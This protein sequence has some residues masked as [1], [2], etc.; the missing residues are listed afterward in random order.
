MA[1]QGKFGACGPDEPLPDGL[2]GGTRFQRGSE[3]R[4]CLCEVLLQEICRSKKSRD[5]ANPVPRADFVGQGERVFERS[6][7]LGK[8]EQVEIKCPQYPIPKGYPLAMLDL[9]GESQTRLRHLQ[10]PCV[11][12]MWTQVVSQ[13]KECIGFGRALA[14]LTGNLEGLLTKVE[15][16]GETDR[17]RDHRFALINPAKFGQQR[18]ARGQP[19]AII[20]FLEEGNG[21]LAIGC[22]LNQVTAKRTCHAQQV[23]CFGKAMLTM[24][25]LKQCE[26][27]LMVAQSF[28]GLFDIHVPVAQAVEA[29]SQGKRIVHAAC[30]FKCLLTI[31][32]SSGV[33]AL[34]PQKAQVHQ[35]LPLRVAVA[36]SLGHLQRGL[37]IWTRPLK[38]TQGFVGLS[39]QAI[40]RCWGRNRSALCGI[41]G[42]R[43]LIDGR[44]R[45]VHSLC[46]LSSTL[47]MLQCFLPQA[48][49]KEMVSQVCQ[50]SIEDRGVEALQRFRNAAVQRLA[51]ADQQ[52]GIDGL[53]RQRM[54]EGELF[55]RLLNEQL[56]RY[57]L[58]DQ[59]E[60]VLFV[61]LREFLQE[62]KVETPSGNC[63]QGQHSPG[64]ITQLI[65]TLLHSILNAARDVQLVQRLT[66]PPTIGVKNLPCRDQ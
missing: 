20:E 11:L 63:R 6:S 52:V 27:L 2:H 32:T 51:F 43:H 37:V 1:S 39:T 38:V 40:E 53:P 64:R 19:L 41:Q 45:S 23:A 9:L 14:N 42:S 29:V 7:C 65:R 49:F 3:D 57:Q 33:I 58:L 4:V 56:G 10:C 26:R 18:Q 59:L 24:R 34:C 50:V 30:Q 8:H 28:T 15:R 5:D 62:G 46:L 35:C 48:R 22:P 31:G 54:A 12:T 16:C 17:G 21:L 36:S 47:P 44:M 61:I 13:A 60:Q 55:R 66:I 25:L